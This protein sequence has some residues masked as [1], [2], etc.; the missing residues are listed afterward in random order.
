MS[1][2]PQLRATLTDTIYIASMT[3]RSS[4]GQPTYGTPASVVARVETDARTIDRPDGTQLSTMHWICLDTT[5]I[6]LLGDRLWLPGIDQT[7]ATK[8]REIQHIE[9]LPGLTD[10]S[11]DHYEVR[12]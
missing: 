7:D 12:V 5:R 4:T 9:R 10:A 3:A 11:T 1:L 6:P 8:A 2:D